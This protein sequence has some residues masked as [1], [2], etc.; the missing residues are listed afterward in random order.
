MGY[1]AILVTVLIASLPKMVV[2]QCGSVDKNS[3]GAVREEVNRL[4]NESLDAMEHTLASG[5]KAATWMPP[6]DSVRQQITCLGP[7]AAPATIE[8]LHTTHRSFGHY[9][10]IR[11][12]GWAG[13]PE[14]VPPLSEILSRTD[15]LQIGFKREA[16]EALVAAPPD[17]ALPVVERVLHSES[18]P[19]LLKEA[20]HVKARLMGFGD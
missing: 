16:L 20:T 5:D 11:M 15:D 8:L 1:A 10:A 12:M 13:G 3:P 9:L 2:G 17:K 7:A 19:A 6:D 18:N 4:F 14:I